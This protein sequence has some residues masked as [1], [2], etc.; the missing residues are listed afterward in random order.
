MQ[1][2]L[3]IWIYDISQ[4]SLNLGMQR[5]QEAGGS[6]PGVKYLTEIDELPDALDLVIVATNAD[7]RLQI[8]R[9]ILKRARV[10]NWVL[11]KVLAQNVASL[12]ELGNLLGGDS[13]CWVNT[14][15][16]MWPLYSLLK[17]TCEQ[18]PVSASFL[19]MEG[20]ACNAIHYIDLISRWS[21]SE[22]RSIDVTG[23]NSNWM[24][25][26][27]PGFFEVTGEFCV[28]FTDGSSLR[29]SSKNQSNSFHVVLSTL[30]EN[31]TVDEAIGRAESDKGRIVIGEV[32]YQ[33]QITASLVQSIFDSGDC[34]LPRLE[35]SISQ[36]KPL[37]ESLLTHWNDNMPEKLKS[38]PIT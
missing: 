36:H 30:N 8:V 33:S 31:W 23:L 12:D 34:K 35:Q 22:I 26:K 5:W 1:Q 24:A 28:N 38:L 13:Q 9:S 2:E 10:T 27:R 11:E 4:E 17:E 15:M 19:E 32:P 7:V 6:S 29:L 21:N 37:L 16:Y 25:S 3:Q 18:G 14:P 20:L